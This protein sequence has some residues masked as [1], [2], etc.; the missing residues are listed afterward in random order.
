M[1]LVDILH[2]QIWV[3]TSFTHAALGISKHHT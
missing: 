3:N 2:I 1:N